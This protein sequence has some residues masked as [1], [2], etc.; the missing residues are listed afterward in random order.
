ME[1]H[2]FRPLDAARRQVTI[3]R[4]ER[5][6]RDRGEDVELRGLG[7]DPVR[8]HHF[9]VLVLDDVVVPD[10]QAGAVE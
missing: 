7:S 6:A 1:T 8:P 9:V 4:L 2:P 10:E 3:L 5:A